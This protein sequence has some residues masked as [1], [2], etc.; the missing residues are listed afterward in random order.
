MGVK[1]ECVL[2][3]GTYSTPSAGKRERVAQVAVY[4]HPMTLLREFVVNW[5][6][7]EMRL[8][9]A[10]RGLA[11]LWKVQSKGPRRGRDTC[12]SSQPAVA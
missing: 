8:P 10:E 6:Q 4:P 3:S 2:R 12:P 1:E 9:V 5:G 11:D 7:T